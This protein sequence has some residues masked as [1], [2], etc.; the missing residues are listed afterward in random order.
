[1]RD[2]LFVIADLGFAVYAD[3]RPVELTLDE[4][5]KELRL[6]SKRWRLS[7]K[8]LLPDP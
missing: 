2:V 3:W 4:V 6:Q 8:R 1:M 7:F 5:V